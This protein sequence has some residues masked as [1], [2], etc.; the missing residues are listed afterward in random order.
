MVTLQAALAVLVL[1]AQPSQTVMLDFSAPWCAPCRAMDPTVRELEARGYPVRHVRFDEDKALV[2]QFQVQ[3]IP[4]FVMVVD[5]REVDRVVGG[6][7]YSRLE[8]MFTTAVAARQSPAAVVQAAPP[9]AMPPVARGEISQ[10]SWASREENPPV[11]DAAL[12]SASVRLRVEDPDGR[13]CGSGTIIDARQGEA[14]ILTCGHI[15][16]DSKGKGPIEVDLF[17]PG[18]RNGLR[19]N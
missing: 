13:S 19:A 7:T 12:I 14:L 10:A 18:A 1:S 15:F 6:T 5:G 17:T 3:K 16:R 4:C 9:A 8:R 2:D 11:A